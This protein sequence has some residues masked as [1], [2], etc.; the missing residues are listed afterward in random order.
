[1]LARP[2]GDTSCEDQY[3][4]RRTAAERGVELW[5]RRKESKAGTGTWTWLTNGSQTDDARVGAAAVS[6]KGDGWMV[7]RSYVG[8]GQMGVFD[9]EL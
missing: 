5:A 2:S 7:T 3:T 4:G 8:K 9:T 1:V 6:W